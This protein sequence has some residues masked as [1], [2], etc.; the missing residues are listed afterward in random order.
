MRAIVLL[1][2]SLLPF[3]Y[4]QAQSIA[5]DRPSSQTDNSTT[6]PKH[7]FQM[8][9]GLLGENLG[10]PGAPTNYLLPN[11][12]MRFGIGSKIEL[13]VLENYEI[14]NNLTSTSQ[15]L[16]DLQVGTK[17]QLFKKEDSK[18]VLAF[19]VHTSIPL[20]FEGISDNQ[21]GALYKL[22]GSYQLS[23]KYAVGYTLGLAHG[24]SGPAEI[25][26]SVLLSRSFGSKFSAFAEVY[27]GFVDGFSTINWDAGISY[28]INNNAQADCYFGTGIGNSMKFL[29]VGFSW[30]ILKKSN[31]E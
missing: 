27:G 20:G 9:Y 31:D 26:L 10:M 23:D 8:E 6:V 17:I 5:T 24:E 13:R 1:T 3:T 2:L 29:S 16:S 30:R 4:G 12:S 11:V 15:G 25:P 21:F 7:C 19:L 14:T 28:L 18:T 22:I